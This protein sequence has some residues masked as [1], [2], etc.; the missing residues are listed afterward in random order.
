MHNLLLSI[1]HPGLHESLTVEFCLNLYYTRVGGKWH[2]KLWTQPRLITTILG[3]SSVS[4][5]F[6]I[7]WNACLSGYVD[8]FIIYYIGRC[9]S[10]MQSLCQLVQVSAFW[11]VP[12]VREFNPLYRVQA[13]TF[14]VA[15]RLGRWL[16][17]YGFHSDYMSDSRGERLW[18]SRIQWK[19]G[20]AVT[21]I[22]ALQIAHTGHVTKVF[23]IYCAEI[24]RVKNS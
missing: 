5:D 15:E 16:G 8:P 9:T 17:C 13:P 6:S 10:D 11:E 4:R 20:I 24:S 12:T 7:L 23:Y 14:S 3:V 22:S 21:P 1:L 18:E 2:I 19:L